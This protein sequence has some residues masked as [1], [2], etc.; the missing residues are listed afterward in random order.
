[1]KMILLALTP[2]KMV[3]IT[4]ETITTL[5]TKTEGHDEKEETDMMTFYLG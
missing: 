5:N 2:L 4:I 3:A 1:M